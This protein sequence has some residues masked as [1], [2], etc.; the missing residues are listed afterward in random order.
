MLTNR[1]P[2]R[3][4]H[5]GFMPHSEAIPPPSAVFSGFSRAS[6]PEDERLPLSSLRFL[7]VHVAA[8]A[9]V[10]WLGWSW[11]GLILA[12][13]LYVVRMFGLT[14]G[15][16]RYFSHR[17][18]KTSR[19]FQF[20]LALLGTSALQKGVLWWAAH[21]R[22]H[23][24]FSDTPQDVHSPVQRGFWWAHIKWVLVPRYTRT[25]LSAVKD[26]A[27]Y[28]EL[29]WL[30]R[31]YLVPPTLL[32]LMLLVVSG[33]WAFVWGFLVSTVLLWHGTFCVN[34]LSHLIGSRRYPTPDQS[35]NNLIIALFTLGEGWH[36][37]HHHYQSSERQGFEWW[38][39]DLTHYVLRA[40]SWLG[41]VWDLRSVPAAIRR[42]PK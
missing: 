8:V 30:D 33:L 16:H 12:A 27:I 25:N 32:A 34:S 38:Q 2:Q 19:A 41:L 7:S 39:I 26:L 13:V 22:A 23:H 40:L 4:T 15:Y 14:A 20:F 6:R 9:G 37:N 11:S 3:R 18:Y 5:A 29:R 17:S 10:V 21:H 35:R 1:L 36:N 24:K 42:S 31:H 28:P